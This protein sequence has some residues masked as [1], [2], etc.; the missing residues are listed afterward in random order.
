[1]YFLLRMSAIATIATIAWANLSDTAYSQTYKPQ[2]NDSTTHT[3]ETS[4]S[5]R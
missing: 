2:K 1:M 4:G 3:G 5:S